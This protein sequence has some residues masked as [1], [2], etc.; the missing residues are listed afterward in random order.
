MLQRIAPDNC[1]YNL[2]NIAVREYEVLSLVQF[3]MSLGR[4]ITFLNKN[5]KLFQTL[6]FI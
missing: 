3:F 4:I 5:L 6:E 1:R 2:L